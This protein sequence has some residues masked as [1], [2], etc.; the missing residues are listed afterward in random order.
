MARDA[1]K[2]FNARW[3]DVWPSWQQRRRSYVDSYERI[4]ALDAA[5]SKYNSKVRS[6]YT[7]T[8]LMTHTAHSIAGLFPQFPWFTTELREPWSNLAGLEDAATREFNHRLKK[9]LWYRKARRWLR[10]AGAYGMGGLKMTYLDGARISLFDPANVAWDPNCDNLRFDAEYA[11]EK[12]ERLSLRQLIALA[13]QGIFDIGPVND[14]FRPDR[15][16]I[17]D[18]DSAEETM[19]QERIR[20]KQTFQGPKGSGMDAPVEMYD[21]VMPDRIISVHRQSQTVLR[22]RDNPYGY[23]FYYDL[24]PF[25]ELFDVGGY[26]VPY[27]LQNVQEEK[28]TFR[29]QRTDIRS[30]EANPMWRFRRGLFDP[31]GFVSKPGKLIPVDDPTDFTKVEHSDSGRP[32]VEEEMILETE[33]DRLIG[34]TPHVRG[35]GGADMKAT[36]ASLLHTNINIRRSVEQNDEVN[37]PIDVFLEDFVALSVNDD[38]PKVATPLEWALIR[39]AVADRS[40]WLTPRQEAHAG[41]PLPKVQLLQQIMSVAAPILQPQGMSELVKRLLELMQVPNPERITKWFIAPADQNPLE[42]QGGGRPGLQAGGQGIGQG[43]PQVEETARA[44]VPGQ[45]ALP[46]GISA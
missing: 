29:R 12:N 6:Q 45:A 8:Q 27:L 38:R 40:L 14:A 36:V 46:M 1:W 24:V 30:L 10:S 32:L 44:Q 35:E 42:Q 43:V 9:E 5:D 22:D 39:Q 21:M 16:R 17:E 18:A 7:H 2:A 25:P 23:I 34:V 31:Y 20:K 13:E 33:G 4:L 41:N 26:S 37:Y 11:I 28:D 3:D 19:A 15:Q